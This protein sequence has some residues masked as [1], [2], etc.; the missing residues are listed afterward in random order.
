VKA[1]PGGVET[2]LNASAQRQALA[3]YPIISKPSRPYEF[4]ARIQDFVEGGTHWNISIPYVTG[5]H[6]LEKR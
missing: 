3:A 6:T 4:Q 2:K 1:P 5:G